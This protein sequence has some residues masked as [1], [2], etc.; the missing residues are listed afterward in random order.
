[1]K[2]IWDRPKWLVLI[3]AG[4][5]MLIILIIANTILNRIIQNKVSEKLQQLSPL[6]KVH[7]SSIQSNLLSSSLSLNN[8]TIAYIPDSTKGQHQHS[9]Y[10][11][12]V[13][14]SGIHFFKV[15]FRHKLSINNLKLSNGE[16]KLDWS[17][18]NKKDT[19]QK[20]IFTRPP[21][22]DISITH[23]ELT[24]IHVWTHADKENQL[25]LSGSIGMDEIQI[26]DLKKA[27]TTNNFH[28][29]AFT[30]ALTD[31]HYAIPGVY[32]N[33]QIKNLLV[34]SKKGTL[35]IDSLKIAPQY[36]K[37][38]LGQKL[39]HQTDI[40]EATISGIAITKLDVLK[41]LQ[42]ELMAEK[43]WIKE[44]NIHVF[45]DRRLL[46]LLQ[47]R[48][49]PVAFLES[50]PFNIRVHL[51]QVVNSVISYEEF[52]KDG[53][54][55]GMLK[56][57]KF[58]LSLSPLINHPNQSDPDHMD[59]SLTG[60]IMGSGT[61]NASVYLPLNPKN[62]YYT[63]GVIDNLELTSLNSSA[64]NLGKFHIE[65]GILN[66]LS[67]HF[68]LNDEKASGKVVGEYHNLI[69]KK[70][71][72]NNKKTAKLKSFILRHVIIPKN[73][74]K[75]LQVANRTG[76]I[77]Y[78]FDHTRFISFYLVKALLSGIESSFTFGFLLPK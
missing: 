25:L 13:E 16:V 7:V 36:N 53:L 8:L 65:S 10:F 76:T 18:L 37:F 57:K 1:M 38:E 29:A 27:F 59:M 60:S 12:A 26:N 58:Q 61:I 52:P 71:K 43:I 3:F 78:K 68:N 73:K 72:G 77:D 55:T 75:S 48:P 66:N 69:V 51:F 56:I 74:D 19:P 47:Y 20:N 15:V 11:S 14:I 64:E 30:G 22:R 24:S 39:G 45:R 42:R 6:L 50:I 33:I 46:R 70:L 63:K 32:H 40:V 17:L 21:F 67:F 44:S 49:L 2:K 5:G 28:F 9:L 62:A 4:I 31:I 23:L 54:K 41:L 34:D 35:Q